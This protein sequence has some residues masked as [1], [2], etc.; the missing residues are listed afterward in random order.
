MDIKTAKKSKVVPL[1]SSKYYT[2]CADCYQEKYGISIV[3]SRENISKK[4]ILRVKTVFMRI[5]SVLVVIKI[6]DGDTK[7]DVIQQKYEH[8]TSQITFLHV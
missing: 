1:R 3:L 6:P 8:L 4:R 5:R 7:R 2:K